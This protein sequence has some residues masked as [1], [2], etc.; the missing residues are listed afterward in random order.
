M[1]LRGSKHPFLEGDREMKCQRCLTDE[2]TYR[3]YTDAL[4]IEVCFVC[5]KEASRLGLAVE[6]LIPAKNMK[7]RRVS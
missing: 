6:M 1:D 4:D 3:I 7:Q 2:A 5:A